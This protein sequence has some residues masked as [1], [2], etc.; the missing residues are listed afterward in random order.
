MDDAFTIPAIHQL[1]LR[2]D[3]FISSWHN[4]P[5]ATENIAGKA[6]TIPILCIVFKIKDMTIGFYE[7]C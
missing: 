6:C 3:V 7:I 4:R 2:A 1:W 5:L